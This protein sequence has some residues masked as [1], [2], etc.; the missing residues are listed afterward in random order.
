MARD[1]SLTSMLA[2]LVVLLCMGGFLLLPDPHSRLRVDESGGLLVEESYFDVF[3]EK[4][5]VILR[6][7]APEYDDA[8][9]LMDEA[10]RQH[11]EDAFAPVY[12]AIPAYADFH[13][14]YVG[15]YT[16]LASAAF[17]G[18]LQSHFERML[19]EETGLPQRLEWS[20]L[21]L[22]GEYRSIVADVLAQ[23]QTRLETELELTPAELGVVSQVAALSYQDAKARLAVTTGVSG[24]VVVGLAVRE[25]GEALLKRV[26]IRGG[27]SAGTRA[28][29]AAAT[30][31]GAARICPGHPYVRVACGVVGAVVG[32]FVVDVA[33]IKADELL[34]GD[35]FVTEVTALIDEEKE[36]ITHEL[37][38]A[39]A[40][41]M[42]ALRDANAEKL[43]NARVI[44]LIE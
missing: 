2:A 11:V 3:K 14:S 16:E 44:D 21:R 32:F 36:R 31:G 28:A 38:S 17:P 15:Q 34:F 4:V 42:L 8:E 23:L 39:Y 13:F 41:Q 9:R 18:Q 30:G 27:V 33:L 43:R 12:A 22:A 29:S 37:Q 10:I 25:I 20:E 24:A 26:V 7:I 6:D 19:I 5:D 1:A 35:A 40:S